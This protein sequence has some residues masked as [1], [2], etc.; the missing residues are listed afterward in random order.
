MLEKIPF[1][2]K[3]VFPLRMEKIVICRIDISVLF[4]FFLH[5]NKDRGEKKSNNPGIKITIEYGK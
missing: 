1:R 2:V 3:F 5:Q 4:F